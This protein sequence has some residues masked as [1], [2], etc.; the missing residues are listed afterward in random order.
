LPF[1]A[2]QC[3]DGNHAHVRR[4]IRIECARAGDKQH[5]GGHHHR[6]DAEIR[7]RWRQRLRVKPAA[8]F[9]ALVEHDLAAALRIGRAA[10]NGDPV[11]ADHRARSADGGVGKIGR[12]QWPVSAM[13]AAAI[14]GRIAINASAV[15]KARVS[16][17]VYISRTPNP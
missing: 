17:R 3:V 9:A 10:E 7:V 4:A 8:A 12:S 16:I 15:A 14:S 11:A 13:L 6:V 1:A 5:V 2:R